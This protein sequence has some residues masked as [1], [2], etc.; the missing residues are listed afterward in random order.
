MSLNKTKRPINTSQSSASQ[1][2]IL[3][4][5]SIPTAPQS[6][7]KDARSRAL[8]SYTHIRDLLKDGNQLAGKDLATYWK[9]QKSKFIW[10]FKC[11]NLN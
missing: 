1:P 6:K 9:L 8:L 4:T 10:S 11:I 7:R 2:I 5:Q 3:P